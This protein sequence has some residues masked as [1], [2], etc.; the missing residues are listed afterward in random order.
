MGLSIE[1][2]DGVRLGSYGLVK[3]ILS[4]HRQRYVLIRSLADLSG[5]GRAI[6]GLLLAGGTLHQSYLWYGDIVVA[7]VK[8][9]QNGRL[10]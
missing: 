6:F 1:W 8:V 9:V 2:R 3:R 5:A 10:E 4:A 7:L